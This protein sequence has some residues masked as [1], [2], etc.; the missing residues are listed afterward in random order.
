MIGSPSTH[1]HTLT[2]SLVSSTYPTHSTRNQPSCRSRLS[3][4]DWTTEWHFQ[5]LLVPFKFIHS[6][7]PHQG[8][9]CCFRKTTKT[10]LYPLQVLVS[11]LQNQYAELGNPLRIH[12]PL[13]WEDWG[14]MEDLESHTPT[15]QG[16]KAQRG[17]GL[18]PKAHGISHLLSWC[19]SYESE[20]F[21]PLCVHA[22]PDDGL[23]ELLRPLFPDRR[24]TAPWPGTYHTH[25]L[26]SA[27]F[28]GKPATPS[29]SCLLGLCKVFN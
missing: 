17:E 13:D 21:H 3:Y 9:K 12:S 18:C 1:H 4:K 26:T 6:A 7:L 19:Q 25:F 28:S 29:F 10:R 23:N 11:P 8:A 16:N 24:L 20:S 27:D 5:W 15:H 22:L 2:R 14:H